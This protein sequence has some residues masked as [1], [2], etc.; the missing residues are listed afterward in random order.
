MIII[1]IVDVVV[2]LCENASLQL[3]LLQNMH[4]TYTSRSLHVS[5]MTTVMNVVRTGEVY[6][7]IS[8]AQS[9][10]AHGIETRSIDDYPSIE[11]LLFYSSFEDEVNK[12]VR[13]NAAH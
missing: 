2:G 13:I 3:L 12:L 5:N 11:P 6:A 9:W 1:F 4:S 7:I 10:Y 8:R